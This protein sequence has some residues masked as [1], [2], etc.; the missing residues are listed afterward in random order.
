M[1]MTKRIPA[2]AAVV[3]CLSLAGCRGCG[4]ADAPAD[5]SSATPPAAATGADGAAS[6][7]SAAAATPAKPVPAVLPPVVARVNGEDITR[8]DLERSIRGVETTLRQRVPGD[9]RD[10]VVRGVLGVHAQF[11]SCGLTIGEE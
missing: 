3:L 5:S 2:A 4:A 8:A 10:G 6:T 1:V 11:R 7:A 9:K